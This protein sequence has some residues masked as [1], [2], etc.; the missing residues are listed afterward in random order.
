VAVVGLDSEPA[1]HA[2]RLLADGWFTVRELTS[3]DVRR[4]ERYRDELVRRDF[5][6]GFDSLEEYLAELDVRVRLAEARPA[7][8]GRISQLTLRTNQFNLTTERLGPEQVRALAEDP[9]ARVLAI[10][11]A[12]R[13]G[14]NG[15]VGAVFVRREGGTARIENFLL[16]CRVFSRGIERACLSAVLRH[17]RETGASRVLGVHRPSAKNGKV[18]RFYPEAGFEPVEAAPGPAAHPPPGGERTFSHDLADI[19]EPPRHVHLT[20][21]PPTSA[22][23]PAQPLEGTAP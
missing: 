12:D 9:S 21:S 15:L 1:L 4:P 16:S 6:H 8:F 7:D 19:L 20:Q 11:S 3:E 5:L 17:A 18:A 13:F 14:D 23:A 22:G 10:H 2:R